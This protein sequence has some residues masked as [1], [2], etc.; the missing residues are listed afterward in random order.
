[1]RLYYEALEIVPED[2]AAEFIRA[3]ITDMTDEEKVDVLQA[4]RDVMARKTYGLTEHRCFHGESPPRKC[5]IIKMEEK[6]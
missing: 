1:M 2:E 3:D 4:I 5:E 6:S